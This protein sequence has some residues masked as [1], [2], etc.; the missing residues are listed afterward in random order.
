MSI[1]EARL[2]DSVDLAEIQV[3]SFRTAYAGILPGAFL[4]LFS[5]EE[6]A[7]DWHELLASS[8]DELLFIATTD[9]GECVGYALARPGRGEISTYDS[10]LVAVHVRRVVQR[11][12]IGKSLIAAIAQ[13]LKEQGRKSLMLWVLE[14]NPARAYYERL[15]GEYI[16]VRDWDGNKDFGSKVREVAYGW[17]DIERLRLA[18]TQP[19]PHQ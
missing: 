3:D 12:G 9:S 2:E 13:R 11:Q 7:Q 4:N 8:T 19:S 17:Q 14:K 10:E 1:R 5:K 18:A 16:K 6:Q 15:G